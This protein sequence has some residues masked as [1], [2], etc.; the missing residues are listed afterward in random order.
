[1]WSTLAVFAFIAGAYLTS[2]ETVAEFRGGETAAFTADQ[3][4]NL[5]WQW[6]LYADA[7]LAEDDVEDGCTVSGPDGDVSLGFDGGSASTTIDG[8]TMY[9]AAEI[10]ITYAGDFGDH[11]VSCEGGLA[12]AF[13]VGYGPEP[14]A[15]AFD[16][17]F[18]GVFGLAAVFG[19]LAGCLLVINTAIVR[20][21]HR[22]EGP[23]VIPGAAEH[24]PQSGQGGPPPGGR[25]PPPTA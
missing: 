17:V 23:D 20:R 25:T 4:N 22:S 19:L 11:T 3:A 5:D 1:M 14:G 10:A 12:D 16:P 6:R 24:P 13:V 15:T 8:E 9:P 21:R 7:P 18:V 2:T